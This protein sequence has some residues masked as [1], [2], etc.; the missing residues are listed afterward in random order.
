M[1]YQVGQKFNELNQDLIDWC[2]NSG[3]YYVHTI[4]LENENFEYEIRE[5]IV[6][7]EEKNE[8]LRKLRGSECY[9]IINR[10]QFWYDTLTEE[11]REELR[12]WYQ[13]WLDV[14]KT[15]TPPK[16]PTWLKR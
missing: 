3:K 7:A 12:E 1:L 13:K 2:N 10:G 4:E 6:T 5:T 14:T 9:P 15:Q 11:Q 16:I 8:H